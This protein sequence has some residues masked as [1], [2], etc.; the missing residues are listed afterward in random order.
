MPL[1]PRLPLPGGDEPPHVRPSRGWSHAVL[2]LQRHLPREILTRFPIRAAPVTQQLQLLAAHPP[3]LSG[4]T[5][6][7][8]LYLSLQ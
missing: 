6:A 7:Q 4:W 2:G 5:G 8:C 1:S 3:K